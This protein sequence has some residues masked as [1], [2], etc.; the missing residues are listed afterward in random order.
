MKD[1]DTHNLKSLALATDLFETRFCTKVVNRKD[2]V[3][4]STPSE[5]DFFWGNFIAF[6]NP[7]RL[8]DYDLW[9]EIYK[10]EFKTKSPKFY[11]FTWDSSELNQNFVSP[12]LEN[13]FKV[14]KDITLV[15]KVPVKTEKYNS[16]VK[17]CKISL[18]DQWEQIPEVHV[19]KESSTPV[20][21]QMQFVAKRMK[22]FKKL[23]DKGYAFRYGAFLDNK[24]V[25]DLGI[26]FENGLARY[27]L[28]ATHRD[29]QRQGICQTLIYESALDLK[30]HVDIKKFVIVADDNYHA[31]VVY[32][33]AGFT[34][35]ETNYSLMWW[36]ENIYGKT[37]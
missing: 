15:T 8:E 33:K 7:P 35:A 23:V 26:L 18:P 24:L 31:Q 37:L 12:F 3:V 6:Y 19:S 34:A 13:G 11:T 28:V 14:E 9:K 16:S 21:N 5:P 29:F 10:D 4:F 22:A 17:I 1:N 25:A 36:D 30:K 2:Y 27:N 20:K 32:K